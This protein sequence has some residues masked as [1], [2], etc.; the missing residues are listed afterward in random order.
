VR[1]GDKWKAT[2]AAAQAL[3]DMVTIDE[4]ELEC[5][6]DEVRQLEQRRIARSSGLDLAPRGRPAPRPVGRRQVLGHHTLLPP[7]QRLGIERLAVADHAGRE[8]H[9][10]HRQF[11]ANLR[12]RLPP[13]RQGLVQQAAAAVVQQVEQHVA[14]RTP[15]PRV[16]DPPR[17]GQPVPP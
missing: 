13:P 10:R 6:F 9:V 12:Q 7:R 17:V 1:P 11:S 4:G 15:T 5:K 8:Q 3:T 16:P 2:K 14:Q